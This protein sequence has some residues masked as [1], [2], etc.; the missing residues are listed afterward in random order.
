MAILNANRV[1]Y[2][3]DAPDTIPSASNSIDK[4]I[5]RNEFSK[6]AGNYDAVAVVQRRIADR[7]IETVLEAQG[8]IEANG[9]FQ[10][11]DA[12]AGTGYV[13]R[14][15]SQQLTGIMQK[16]LAE[17]PKVE[18][19]KVE[20]HNSTIIPFTANVTAHVATKPSTA[21]I[22]PKVTALDL[23]SE[24]LAVAKKQGGYDAYIAG[25]IEALPCKDKTFDLVVS[26]LA[27]QWCH[28]ITQALK[29]LHRVT[30]SGGR[31]SIATIIEG[32]LRELESAFKTVDN[33]QH[34]LAFLT[35][36]KLKAE[37]MALGGCLTIYEEIVT[38]DSLKSLF[39]SL[40][41]IGATSLP[42]RRKGLLGRSSIAKLEQYF[43]SIGGYQLT[44]V[45]ALIDIPKHR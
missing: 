12:G 11:L 3:A 5:I 6:N 33:E 25:D 21:L 9:A 30:K 26:S 22:A 15:L 16:P 42:N 27:I 43:A 44:Y 7:L 32:T 45:V 41:H 37:V 23:S 19:P 1:R 34:I 4:P 8:D 36:E 31:I 38:F 39:K 2:D 13:G 14:M 18:S 10:V 17:Q 40:K 35:E 29:E 20:K 24:M 28:D